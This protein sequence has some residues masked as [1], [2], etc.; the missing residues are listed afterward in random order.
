MAHKTALVTGGAS[1]IGLAMARYLA[2]HGDFEHVAILDV[3]DVPTGCA[4]AAQLSAA[5]EAKAPQ[6]RFVPCDVSSWTAQAAAFAEVKAQCGGRIDVVM[7][8]A[9]ISG[10]NTSILGEEGAEP[11]KPSLRALDIN[12]RGVIYCTYLDGPPESFG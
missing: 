3:V 11:Q 4:L 6:V 7:A 12:L 2:N 1:G 9:G 8:N 10:S 5:P